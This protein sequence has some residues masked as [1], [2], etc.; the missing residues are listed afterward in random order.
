[1]EMNFSYWKVWKDYLLI[2][3][4]YYSGKQYRTLEIYST[5]A[6]HF[7]FFMGKTYKKSDKIYVVYRDGTLEWALHV[8]YCLIAVCLGM[9]CKL[10]IICLTISLLIISTSMKILG[11]LTPNPFDFAKLFQRQRVQ[12]LSSYWLTHFFDLQGTL[13]KRRKADIANLQKKWIKI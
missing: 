9:V 2:F 4:F 13:L 7:V 1:M 10:F 12:Y 8:T 5:P 6:G 11:R 3:W